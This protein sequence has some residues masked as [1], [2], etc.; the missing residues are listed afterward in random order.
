MRQIILKY[1]LIFLFLHM[2]F[3]SIYPAM[4][5]TNYEFDFDRLGWLGCG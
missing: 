3:L 5:E 4:G 2:L 1:A